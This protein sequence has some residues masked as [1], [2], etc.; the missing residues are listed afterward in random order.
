MEPMRDL[1]DVAIRRYLLGLLPDGEAE[2]VEDSYF[3]RPEAFD[4][5]RG[6]EDDLIDDYAAGLLPASERAA[7]ESR[8]LASPGLRHRLLAARALRMARS[9]TP[10]TARPL[11]AGMPGWLSPLAIAAA[12]ILLI[13]TWWLWRAPASEGPVAQ[14][15]AGRPSPGPSPLLPAATRAVFALSPV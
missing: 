4:G 10:L 3:E 2:A 5:V 15:P 12:L 1:D 11:A 6:V 9:P 13:G 8:Y 7:F 14:R